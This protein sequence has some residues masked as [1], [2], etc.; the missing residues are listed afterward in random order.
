MD[1]LQGAFSADQRKGHFK[2][3]TEAV[4]LLSYTYLSK[5]LQSSV[6]GICGARRGMSMEETLEFVDSPL[7]SCM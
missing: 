7:R 1:P 3:R 5:Y 2:A 4:A 6:R